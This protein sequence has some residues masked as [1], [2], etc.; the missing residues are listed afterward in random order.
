MI[1][2]QIKSC[3][4]AGVFTKL[5]GGDQFAAGRSPRENRHVN[6]FGGI[7]GIDGLVQEILDP[8]AL[9]DFVSDVIG[10]EQM[11]GLGSCQRLFRSD[12]M[13][14]SRAGRP[15]ISKKLLVMLPSGNA[16]AR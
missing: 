14:V 7:G 16:I 13:P 8:G 1:K 5:T 3:V 2:A 11:Q 10:I 4:T 6:Q 15:N 12:T 9:L